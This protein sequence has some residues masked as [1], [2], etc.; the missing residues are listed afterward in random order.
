MHMRKIHNIAISGLFAAALLTLSVACNPVDLTPVSPLAPG[1]ENVG[2]EDHCILLRLEPELARV[3]KTK[4]GETERGLD[5]LN[6]NHVNSIDVFFYK[7][8]ETDQPAI[9]RAVGR[10]VEENTAV[11][12]S[13]ECYVKVYYNDD[14][15]QVLFGST[16]Q[17]SCEAFVIANA[18]INYSGST[19]DELRQSVLEYDFSQQEVQPFFTMCSRE[20]AQ[21]TLYTVPDP[22]DNTRTISTA[23]GRVPLYRCAAKAQLFLKLPE[24]LKDGADGNTYAPCPEELGGIQVRL[25]TGVKKTY[26]DAEYS[27]TAQDYIHFSDRTV[28]DIAA[29]PLTGVTVVPGKEE[30]NYGH[31]PFYSYPMSWSDLDDNAANFI[32]SIPWK[33]VKDADGNDVPDGA[34]ERRY[35]KLSANVI[36]R[37]FEANGFYRT[38]VYVQS[39]GDKE[40]DEAEEIDECYYLIQPWV[41]EGVATGP[42]SESISGQF[43]RYTFLVVEPDEVTLNNET[44]YTFHFSSSSDLKD[45]RVTIDKVSF[46][47]YNT[48]VGVLTERNVNAPQTTVAQRTVGNANFIDINEYTVTYNYA[49]GEIYF[50]HGLDDVYEQRDIYLT[51]T[52]KDN[53]SQQ[54]VI[55][56]KPAIMVNLNSDTK[57]GDVFVDGF[58]ARLSSS[59]GFGQSTTMRYPANGTAQWSGTFWYSGATAPGNHYNPGNVP[60]SGTS[61]NY[62]NYG[63]ISTGRENSENPIYTLEVDVSAF[64]ASNHTYSYRR[65]GTSYTSEYRIADPRVQANTVYGAGWSLFP[66]LTGKPNNNTYN[67][68]NWTRPGEILITVQADDKQNYIAPKFLVSSTLNGQSDKP[69]FENTVKRA[70]V[71]QE[72]GFPAGR[73][74][75]PTEAELAFLFDRQ[76]DGTIPN[77]FKT[78]GT[79]RYRAASGRYM[80]VNGETIN[81]TDNDNQ[82]VSS[83]FIY[84][85]W[86]WG[87]TPAAS[88]VYHPNGH[89]VNY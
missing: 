42:G 77:L 41:H 44:D 52:N 79:G 31:V 13:T 49:K 20:T 43:V 87:D 50:H 57:V 18:T 24:T 65:S 84:D 2:A 29:S 82:S 85:L 26:A 56:Q 89:I 88:N 12:D 7:T 30:Y 75:L 78:D 70:A 59:P 46:Y 32:F 54:V 17:G 39:R 61:Y 81:F 66:Y 73:W 60:V 53:I 45:S 33:L 35:Y 47:K 40:L 4:A 10:T 51:V 64:S 34:P 21:V 74:R 16:T 22:Y 28:T 58:F 9:F 76:R 71:Y 36:G 68:E 5:P 55:H 38:F 63:S 1:F 62:G 11:P 23:A 8:G 3:V 48:G 14:I 27:V 25:A 15:A 80:T 67:G 69:N 72:A 83:R 86:Y 37:K 19:V 6:E